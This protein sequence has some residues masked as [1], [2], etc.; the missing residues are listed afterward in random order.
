MTI[1]KPVFE[2]TDR[3]SPKNLQD[4]YA[5]YIMW[6]DTDMGF[7]KNCIFIDEASF[8]INMLSN[9]CA[10]RSIATFRMN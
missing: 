9:C 7:T 6:K 5:W 3:N 8:H 2:S 10:N 1:K 4:R